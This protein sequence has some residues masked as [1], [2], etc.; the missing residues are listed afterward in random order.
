MSTK[1]IRVWKRMCAGVFNPLM[2]NPFKL[3][4][5][6]HANNDYLVLLSM[7]P[8]FTPPPTLSHLIC[9]KEKKRWAADWQSSG[10]IKILCPVTT[11]HGSASP[12][13]YSGLKI[14]IWWLGEQL[15][16]CALCVAFVYMCVC[17]G[18]MSVCLGCHPQSCVCFMFYICVHAI[19]HVPV[20]VC[21]ERLVA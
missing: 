16:V 8:C 2:L 7:E 1:R 20:C 21:T 12:V 17:S 15:C 13:N 3:P 5:L 19:R 9:G 6:L 10:L 14:D 11:Q 4:N 18:W